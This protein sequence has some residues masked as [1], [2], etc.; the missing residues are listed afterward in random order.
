[1]ATT[2]PTLADRLREIVPA[3][4]VIDD[5]ATLLPYAYDASFWSLRQQRLPDV[6]VVPRSTAEVASVVRF[7]DATGT[8][9]VPRGAGHGSD[10]RR[11][12]R[13]RWDRDL[14]RAD[15][16][17][18]GDRSTEPAGGRGAGDRLRRSSRRAPAEGP[19]LSAGSRERA[20]VHARRH[21]REQ[22]ER[23][24]CRA[25]GNDVGIRARRGDRSGRWFGHHHGWRPLEGAQVIERHRP[26]QALRRV[27]GDAWNH[28]APAS[29]R[30]AAATGARRR[31]RGLRDPGGHRRVARRSLRSGD[32]AVDSGAARPQ[33]GGCSP[34][35]EAR[36]RPP[37][38]RGG[39]LHRGRGHARSR[40][41][42]GAL[43]RWDRAAACDHDEVRRGRGRDRE[44]V[45]RAQR[46]RRGG[47]A[48]A[49]R[50]APH[51]RRRGSRRAP[52]GDPAHDP[53]RA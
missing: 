48:G 49:S 52:V 13:A 34:S 32:T 41:I 9:V 11:D 20:C 50:Q 15:A 14:V 33:R 43:R 17:D 31:P 1:M 10:R 45:G 44:A 8:P 12:R 39:P 51:L 30:T 37:R 53:P 24:A 19:L 6:V 5:P 42:V 47:R 28:H 36:A 26:H 38:G 35:L 27:G 40:R 3:D 22:R 18:P 21:G 46:P 25:V 16:R 4:R 23:A 2:T 29:S 7:A